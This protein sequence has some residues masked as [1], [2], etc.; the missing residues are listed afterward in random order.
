VTAVT[1]QR[2]WGFRARLAVLIASVFVIAGAGLLTVQYLLV[3]QLLN[4]NIA[5]LTTACSP[6]FPTPSTGGAGENPEGECSPLTDMPSPVAGEEVSTL[7]ATALTGML[8]QEVLSGLLVWS[9][10]VL[11]VFAGVA[12]L[13]GWWLSKRSL[14]RIAQITATTRSL[15]RDDLHQ[16]LD[17]PGPADEIKELG[18]TIDGMLDRLDDAFTRQDRFIASASH[19]LRTPLTTARTALEIPLT[20]GR[21]PA[22]IEP[23]IRRA[24]TANERSEQLITALLLL[25][26]QTRPGSIHPTE[27]IDVS[28][29]VRRR[30]KEHKNDSGV[31]EIRLVLPDD[32]SALTAVEPTLA[33]VAMGNLIDNALRHG[34]ANGRICLTVT[35]EARTVRLTIVNDGAELS[36]D[37]A[38]RLVEPFNRGTATRLAGG[39]IGLGLT[40]VDTI[41]RAH[42]GSL[43][44]TP[45][46]GGGLIAE[47]KLPSA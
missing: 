9:V 46:H 33:E 31:Q 16:R 36:A 44:L 28:S 30:I 11:V 15:S 8:S 43:T 3:H 37:Q 47:L 41:A 24:L 40:I 45:R 2:R 10:V 25:A 13:A 6:Y 22:D 42:G 32:G 27:S 35:V 7:D 17:L 39:G 12:M 21:I 19:E 23:D 34:A 4:T 14:G 29:L 18:D 1:S 38:T 26:R 5:S 20:Q